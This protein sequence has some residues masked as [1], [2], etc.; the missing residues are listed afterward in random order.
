M[1]FFLVEKKIISELL[2]CSFFKV[3]AI[4]IGIKVHLS[5]DEEVPENK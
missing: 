1:F 5:R 4:K 2:F 3:M